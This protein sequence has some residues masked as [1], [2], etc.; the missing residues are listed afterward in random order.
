[1]SFDTKANPIEIFSSSSDSSDFSEYEECVQSPPSGTKED[2]ITLLSDSDRED[3]ES[4]PAPVLALGSSKRPNTLDHSESE[5]EPPKKKSRSLSP[6]PARLRLF[7]AIPAN[8]Q[9]HPE[10]LRHEP[11]AAPASLEDNFVAPIIDKSARL[12]ALLR[13]P[14]R[15]PSRFEFAQRGY[16]PLRKVTPD[17]SR[18][19]SVFGKVEGEGDWVVV[20]DEE[21]D[22]MVVEDDEEEVVV[23][24][25]VDEDEGYE[26]DEY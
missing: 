21:D 2:P 22:V 6:Q 7:L 12:T 15:S 13:A 1:M 26:G 19:P 24:L 4:T 16:E 9:E 20:E 18:E 14:L 8:I 17:L 25:K 23:I 11:A 10:L 5:E 3:R